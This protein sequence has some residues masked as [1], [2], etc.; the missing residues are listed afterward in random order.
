MSNV[1]NII[2]NRYVGNNTVL[3]PL[4]TNSGEII[5][6]EDVLSISKKKFRDDEGLIY[7]LAN[8]DTDANVSADECCYV[9]VENNICHTIILSDNFN[10]SS[11]LEISDYGSRN[12]VFRGLVNK[13]SAVQ[14]DKRRLASNN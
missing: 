10:Q 14:A 5:F 12:I 9:R 3:T 2:N 8:V 1:N 7:A 4:M 11:I 6:L 13:W